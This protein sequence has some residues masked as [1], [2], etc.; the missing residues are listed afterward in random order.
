LLE[1]VLS[2]SKFLVGIPL[3]SKGGGSHS[4][5]AIEKMGEIDLSTKC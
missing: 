4:S 3:S 2:T 5:V 1:I